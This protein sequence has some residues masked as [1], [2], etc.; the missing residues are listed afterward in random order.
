MDGEKGNKARRGSIL[1]LPCGVVSDRLD[2]PVE[3][4]AERLGE[5]LLD[6][7]VELLGEDNGEARIDIVL[8]KEQ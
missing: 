7:D 8:W 3:L 2:S 5:K 4:F 1:E 6:R